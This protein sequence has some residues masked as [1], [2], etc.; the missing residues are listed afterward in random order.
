MDNQNNNNENVLE[1]CDTYIDR[2]QR[3][4]EKTNERPNCFILPFIFGDK[5]KYFSENL[6]KKIESRYEDVLC[7]YAEEI[8]EGENVSAFSSNLSENVKEIKNGMAIGKYPNTDVIYTPIIV[9]LSSEFTS[10]INEYIDSIISNIK[11][12]YQIKMDIYFLVD[13]YGENILENKKSAVEKIKDYPMDRY[14]TFE[15]IYF[16]GESN[17]IFSEK[18]LDVAIDTVETNIFYKVTDKIK[19]NWK[20]S[21]DELNA[22]KNAYSGA[23]LE[24]L[25]CNWVSLGY[26]RFDICKYLILYHLKEFIETQIGKNKDDIDYHADPTSSEIKQIEKEIDDYLDRKYPK[27]RLLKH[28]KDIP[29]NDAKIKYIKPEKKGILGGLFNKKN[30]SKAAFSFDSLEERLFDDRDYFIKYIELNSDENIEDFNLKDK[31]SSFDLM[32]KLDKIL[33]NLM[34]STNTM[35]DEATNK[36]AMEKG[37]LNKT[38][39]LSSFMGEC[40]NRYLKLKLERYILNKKFELIE[41]EVERNKDKKYVDL[42]AC[43]QNKERTL[44]IINNLMEKITFNNSIFKG[45]VDGLIEDKTP[46]KI[47]VNIPWNIGFK[48]A[49]DSIGEE[50]FIELLSNTLDEIYKKDMDTLSREF[51]NAMSSEMKNKYC[52]KYVGGYSSGIVIGKPEPIISKDRMYCDYF[53]SIMSGSTSEIKFE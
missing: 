30:T 11:D 47:F 15:D 29:I 28:I 39:D 34:S 19:Y 3:K 4:Q 41:K 5:T 13:S 6:L 20:V 22:N 24:N 32:N 33:N 51:E 42:D 18:K 27:D 14:I 7:Y 25:D 21:I 26:V 48:D 36:L 43:K 44:V 8:K 49:V 16:L 9:M 2:V 37:F 12:D 40:N 53:E 50:K 35:L 52:I 1:I 31:I 38:D 45:V 10:N 23:G 17:F 46:H